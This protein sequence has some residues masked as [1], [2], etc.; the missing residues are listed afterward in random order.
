MITIRLNCPDGERGSM[1]PK[2]IKL[3]GVV[4]AQ[5]FTLCPPHVGAPTKK[6]KGDFFVKLSGK[7]KP[8]SYIV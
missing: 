7:G 3:Q 8:D 6:A 4:C 1:K 2:V 5:C